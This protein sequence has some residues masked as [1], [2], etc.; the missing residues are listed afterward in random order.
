MPQI[1][2]TAGASVG[3][4]ATT[5]DQTASQQFAVFG[6][7]FGAAGA[8][9]EQPPE[10]H[11]AGRAAGPGVLHGPP[12]GPPRLDTHNVGVESL[13]AGIELDADVEEFDLQEGVLDPIPPAVIAEFLRSV[14]QK[15]R[16]A[17]SNAGT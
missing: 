5:K 3:A 11:S 10:D 16:P 12:A 2:T 8:A 17:K 7:I 4:A 9:A 13:L 6:S 1:H 15:A 14:T